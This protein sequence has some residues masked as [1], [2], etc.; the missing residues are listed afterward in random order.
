MVS[1]AAKI[2]SYGENCWLQS[3]E[4]RQ[5]FPRKRITLFRVQRGDLLLIACSGSKVP[6]ST[7]V[8]GGSVVASLEPSRASA[9][10]AAREALQGPAAVDERTLMPAYLR[11]S[12]QL[13]EHGRTAVRAALEAGV[14][15]GIVS[16]GYG[17]LDAEEGIGLYEKRFSVSDWPRGLLERCIL[18]FAQRRSARNVVAVMSAST[19][20]GK[21]IRRIP[22]GNGISARLVSP[23]ADGGGAMVKVPRAQG[24]IVA[25]LVGPGLEEGWRSTDGLAFKVENLEWPR[26]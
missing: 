18:D 16:G 22:R 20:Y 4:T 1:L 26:Q 9:L 5:G 12:G 10:Q 6:G 8:S 3:N 24:Q 25:R 23:V 14:T 7:P 15:V 17:V 13:Y 21:L 2:G 19:D 11:Y